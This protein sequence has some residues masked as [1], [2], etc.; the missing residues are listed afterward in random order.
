MIYDVKI[1]ENAQLDMKTIYKYIADV[2]MEPMIAEKQYTHIETAVCS[3]EQMPERFRRY[4][5]E[6]WRSCNLRIMPVDN[7]TVFYTVD[8]KKHI[9][10][11]VRIMYGKRDTEREL[12]DTM[13]PDN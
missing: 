10:T 3:L 5:K 1:S 8:N 13:P 9:V 12:G 7:Y 6:P 11:V 2:L 4:E